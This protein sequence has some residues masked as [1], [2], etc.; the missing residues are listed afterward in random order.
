MH[1]A[2]KI[3]GCCEEESVT[4]YGLCRILPD[5]NV[6]RV[7]PRSQRA[8]AVR[9]QSDRRG[10]RL[11]GRVNVGGVTALGTR[12]EHRNVK[13]GSESGYLDRIIR[14]FVDRDE[15]VSSRGTNKR[16]DNQSRY[17]QVQEYLGF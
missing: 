17:R 14:C 8:R 12:R 5:V 13:K 16:I 6:E 4:D 1:R 11:A 3:N 2:V 9:C 7:I 10:F 15:T